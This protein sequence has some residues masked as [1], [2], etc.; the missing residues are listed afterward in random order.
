MNKTIVLLILSDVF[1]LT[2]FGLVQ[3][4]LSIFIKENL[5]GGTIF[6][7]G[8]AVMLFI[9]TKSIVQLPLSRIIDKRKRGFRIKTM[10]VGT[11]VVSMV[12]FIYI[13]SN[14]VIFIY[15]AQII[16]GIGSGLAYPSWMAIWTKNSTVKHKSFDWSVYS[17]ATGIGTGIAAL[18]GATI[19]E[20]F[21]FVYTFLL[22]GFLSLFACFALL[23]LEMKT[24]Q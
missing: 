7:A 18:I 13:F 19:A 5:V 12:P 2:G 1:L 6:A 21:G 20:F 3:P 23:G 9:L 22:V 15:F 4:I 16:Y 10:I 24:T 11:F 8:I 17:T 14:Y